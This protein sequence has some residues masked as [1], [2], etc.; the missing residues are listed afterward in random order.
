MS[1]AGRRPFLA[2][3]RRHHRRHQPQRQA[4]G[5]TCVYLECWHYDFEDFLELRKNTGD[6]RRRTH[7]TNMP[8]GFPTCS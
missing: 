7:D 2:D 4:A 8:A 6:E 1:A 3:R 5:A